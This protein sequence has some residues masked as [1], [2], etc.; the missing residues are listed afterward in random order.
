MRKNNK[1]NCSII[2]NIVSML[3]ILFILTMFILHL[4]MPNKTFSKE[5]Q[6]YLAQW[7]DFYIEKVI[8][9]SYETKVEAYFSDQFPFRNF[10]VHIQEDFNEI[11]HKVN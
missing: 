11:F 3:P 7:P 9:G 5:E 6:R 8:D 4:V 10:W 2:E 1:K